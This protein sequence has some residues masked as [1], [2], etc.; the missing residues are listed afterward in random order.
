VGNKIDEPAELREVTHAE[1]QAQAAEWGVQ[2]METSAKTNHNVTEL[3]QVRIINLL[4]M[5]ILSN[6]LCN[7]QELLNMEKNRNVSLTDSKSNKKKSKSKKKEQN[8]NAGTSAGGESS[9][10]KEK[11]QVM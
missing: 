8:G 6:L 10:A 2:F 5:E 11:C 9:G 1:G 4:F 7:L 3:F